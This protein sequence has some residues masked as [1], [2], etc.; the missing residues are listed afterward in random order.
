MKYVLALVPML[1]A[2][3]ANA[4]LAHYQG[5]SYSIQF[6]VS[7]IAR[8]SPGDE[9]VLTSEAPL[10]ERREDSEPMN[11]DVHFVK[12]GLLPKELSLRVL[13]LYTQCE[14]KIRDDR[15]D[16]FNQ[17]DWVEVE[18]LESKLPAG[19]LILREGAVPGRSCPMRPETQN[20][21][22]DEG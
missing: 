18:L 19:W 13:R 2:A 5:P 17:T 12:Q 21:G 11:R 4:E 9:I 16:G 8:L 15:P 10:F 20:R 6:R 1:F 22:P 14:P 3:T 7:K